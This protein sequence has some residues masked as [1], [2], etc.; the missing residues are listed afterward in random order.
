MSGRP[1]ITITESVEVLLEIGNRLL[2]RQWDIHRTRAILCHPT[3]SFLLP[4]VESRKTLINNR[5]KPDTL[6]AVMSAE[7]CCRRVSALEAV[8]IK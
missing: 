8:Q 3:Q 2:G 5:N 6:T 7:S 4:K 1:H